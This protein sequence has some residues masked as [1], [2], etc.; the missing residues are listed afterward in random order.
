ME[1]EF[2]GKTLSWLWF[3]YHHM[4]LIAIQAIKEEDPRIE[5]P[6]VQM[7]KVVNELGYRGVMVDELSEANI[8]NLRQRHFYMMRL[9]ERDQG[10]E[11]LPAQ[12][13]LVVEELN[14]RGEEIEPVVIA[15]KALRLTARAPAAH[16]VKEKVNAQFQDNEH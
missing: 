9:I 14:R 8:D 3:W 16:S 6:L 7:D 13:R 5:N 15:M 11:T 2:Q 10:P 12:C 4:N 1:R